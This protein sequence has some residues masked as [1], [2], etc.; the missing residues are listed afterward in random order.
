MNNFINKI[1]KNQALIYKVFLFLITSTLIVYLFP[2]G[3][4][5]KY[6]LAKGKPWQYETLYAPFDFAIRKSQDEISQEKREIEQNHAPYF[7]YK[8]SIA[9][10]VKSNLDGKI[11]R[12]FNDSI[13]EVAGL[14]LVKFSKAALDEIYAKGVIKP[15]K[16][17]DDS[18]IILLKRDNEA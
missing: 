16:N 6:E 1:Y 18:Q 7:D 15:R 4:K 17:Y 3:G 11:D 5:F 10:T 13:M 8:K 2:K 14:Q 12:T 9:D